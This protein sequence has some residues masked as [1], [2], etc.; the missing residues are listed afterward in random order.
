MT[1]IF[2]AVAFASTMALVGC[3]GSSP[4]A[5]HGGE[6]GCGCAQAGCECTG[7]NCPGCRGEGGGCASS[8]CPTDG[9]GCRCQGGHAHGHEHGG[10]RHEHGH[11]EGHNEGGHGHHHGAMSAEL[12]ALHEVL[13]PVWH[14][15]PGAER[16]GLACGAAADLSAK[17]T[18]V[19]AAAAPAGVDSAAWAAQTTTMSTAFGEMQSACGATPRVDATVEAKLTTAHDAFHALIDMPRAGAAH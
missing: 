19:G 1:K 6:G 14:S 16:V 15:T 9:E 3:G 11:G 17:S 8:E 5:A 12:H 10:D 13:R 7:E 4:R 18:A 2:S